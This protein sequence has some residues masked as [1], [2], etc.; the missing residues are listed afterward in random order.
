MIKR[1]FHVFLALA[2]P[3]YVFLHLFVKAIFTDKGFG[4][5]WLLDVDEMINLL[6]DK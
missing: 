1:L 5:N 3:I 4:S 2:F 6:K